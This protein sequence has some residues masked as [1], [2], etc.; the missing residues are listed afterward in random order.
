MLTSNNQYYKELYMILKAELMDEGSIKRSL[1]RI[2]HE[3]I[4]RNRDMSSVCLVG[5]K[6]RGVPIAHIIADNIRRFDGTDAPIGELNI[7]YYR[8][9]LSDTPEAPEL[10]GVNIPVEVKDHNIILVDDVIF[11]GRTVRAAI[12]AVFTCGR[13]ASIQLA[14]LI[15]RGHRELPI[16]PDFVG[17]N[18]PT[19]KNE[20]VQLE[21]PPFD[22]QTRVLLY[23]K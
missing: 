14:A 2:T 15:D 23:T 8:D 12:E 13:P 4:E 16:R 6:S 22:E 9:D 19:A 5:I 7:E 17:K 11:T 20:L 18:I 3:I 10:S 1:M 21:I